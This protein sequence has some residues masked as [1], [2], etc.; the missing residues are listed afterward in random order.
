VEY[1][2]FF[3][4]EGISEEPVVIPSELALWYHNV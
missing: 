3:V 2:Y 1:N 4:K